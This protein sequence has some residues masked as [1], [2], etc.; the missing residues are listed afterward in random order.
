MS[1]IRKHTFSL[2][3]QLTPLELLTPP[4]THTLCAAYRA[5]C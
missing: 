3:F 4:P 1:F 2:T 5:F